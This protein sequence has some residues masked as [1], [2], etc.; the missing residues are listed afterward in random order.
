MANTTVSNEEIMAKLDASFKELVGGHLYEGGTKV[1]ADAMRVADFGASV[2]KPEY[3]E[4]FVICATRES[5]IFND[6]RRII[7][8]SPIVGIDRTGFTERLLEPGEELVTPNRKK[9]KF[10]QERL[11]ARELIGDVGISDQALRRNK[12]R[13]NYVSLMIDMMGTQGGQDWESYSVLC[14]TNINPD[15]DPLLASNDGWIAKARNHIYGGGRKQGDDFDGTDPIAMFNE[16]LKRYPKNYLRNRRNLVF[17]VD[18]DVY[19]DYI[20]IKGER[21]TI[22]G[23][24]TIETNI[25]RPYKGVRVEEAPVLNEARDIPEI[26]ATAMLV[27]PNNLVYGIFEEVTLEPERT[28]RGRMTDYVMTMEV[29]QAYENPYVA[30][31]AHPN[32]KE[33]DS[34]ARSEYS[35]RP[36]CREKVANGQLVPADPD[37]GNGG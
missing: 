11:V 36:N 27:D 16:M 21:P 8:D 17:Y 25:A 26:D 28:A 15:D 34:L 23:D 22:V 19:S 5:T 31:I 33:E 30:V 32:T 13:E 37:T 2:L 6:A 10:A 24:N 3:F 29:D 9:P 12:M 20:D 7:M 4:D 35:T 18:S 14:N 1:G